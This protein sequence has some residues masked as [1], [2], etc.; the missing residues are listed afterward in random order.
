M[1]RNRNIDKGVTIHW[2]GVDLPN[3]EDGV[4]GATQNAVPP[5]QEHVYR[6][7]A[8][9]VGTFWYHAHQA[10]A[11]EV[12]RGLYGTLVIEPRRAPAAGVRDLAVTVHTLEAHRS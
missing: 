1:L 12:R 4:A 9:Q 6:F 2:H 5:G 3:A 10:S 7:R 8:G 11:D